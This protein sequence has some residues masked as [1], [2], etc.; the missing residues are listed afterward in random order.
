M[1]VNSLKRNLT[2]DHSG[3]RKRTRRPNRTQARPIPSNGGNGGD[4]GVLLNGELFTE[5]MP[6]HY[7][8]SE[9]IIDPGGEPGSGPE[10]GGGN[11]CR[12]IPHSHSGAGED[13]GVNQATLDYRKEQRRR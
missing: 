4:G 1:T 13:R 6:D 5:S 11:P 10:G 12:S 9:T 3:P 8:N 2:H 7:E